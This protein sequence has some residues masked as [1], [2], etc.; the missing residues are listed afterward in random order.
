MRQAAKP[1]PGVSASNLA[2]YIGRVL[3]CVVVG[4]GFAGLAAAVEL[5]GRGKDVVVLEARDRIGGRVATYEHEGTMIEVGGQ[6]ISPGHD[7]MHEL[8][9]AAGVELIGPQEGALLIR[10]QGG[11]YR[12]SAAPDRSHALTPFEMAD[13]GQGMLRFRRLAQRVESDRS[14]AAANA[15]WLGQPLGRWVKANLRTPAAQQDFSAVLASVSDGMA[16][17][18]SLGRALT[19]TVQGTDLES[20]F[21]VSGGLKLR[22][23]MGGMH[24]LV[25]HLAAKLDDRVKLGQIVTRIDHGPDGV[26]VCTEAADGTSSGSYRARRVLVTLPPWLA[27]RLEYN[28]PL[29][30]WREEVLHRNTA[31]HVI[32]AFV[33]YPTPWWREQGLSGQMSAD[34][35]S[36]RVTFD[37]SEQSGPG[38]MMGF[39]EGAE[40]ASM[41]KRSRTIRELAFI[42]SLAA[43]FGEEVRQPHDY[44]DYDWAADKYTRGCHTPHFAPGVWSVNGQLLAEPV[45]AIHFAGSEYVGK[46]NGYLEGAVRSGRE[47]AKAILRELG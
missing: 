7:S 19:T 46:N 31:G 22:R 18:V 8:V 25:D 30:S 33:L 3:D 2:R 38:I 20:L 37:I 34:E 36:V 9:E 26:T 15:S 39:F 13:L 24:Q 17:D 5:S 28:P 6:W 47:E 40:A 23:V 4:A 12:S 35:G 16:G 29:P 32:K 41:S 45:D 14:W 10:S 27:L 44:L 21:A 1:G 11:V 43:V 42:D